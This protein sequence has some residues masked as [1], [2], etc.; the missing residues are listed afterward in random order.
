MGKPCTGGARC[1]ASLTCNA[2]LEQRPGAFQS[3]H[4]KVLHRTQADRF[5][6]RIL[7]GAGAHS[8][9]GAQV[10]QT[11][12]LLLVLTHKLG[13]SGHGT[14]TPATRNAFCWSVIFC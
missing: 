6:E 10:Q 8:G 2:P 12:I 7:E 11:D 9:N 14:D 13:G 3:T 5:L 1:D 4:P